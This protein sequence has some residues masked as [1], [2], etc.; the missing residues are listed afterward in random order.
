MFRSSTQPVARRSRRTR[1][2]VRVRLEVEALERRWVPSTVMNLNDSGSGSL[3]QAILD[4]AAGGTVDFQPGLSGTITLTSGELAIGNDL[5]IIGPGAA[6]LTV[7][8]NHAFRIFDV[9]GSSVAVS[10]LTLTAGLS[11]DT[12]GAVQNAGTLRVTACVFS[13]NVVNSQ[14]GSYQGGGAV[15]NSGV[16]NVTDCTLSNN[17]ASGD[18]QNV[19]GGIYNTGTLTVMN[20]VVTGNSVGDSGASGARKATGA[21]A[22][23]TT[24]A[25]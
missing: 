13:G 7:S 24:G 4:T 2:P 25:T 3:R 17:A 18:Q 15:F 1:A 10:G 11:N 16:L 19:G 6:A 20:S 22:F 21:V 12:G 9:I 5:T 23:S 14:L 8:G